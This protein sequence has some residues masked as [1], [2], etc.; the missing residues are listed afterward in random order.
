MEFSIPILLYH[1]IDEEDSVLSTRPAV[2]RKHLQFLSERGWRSLSL[3]EFTFYAW[4][5]KK[6]PSR[7]FFITFD[8]GYASLH[9]AAAKILEEFN[10]RATCFLCTSFIQHPSSPIDLDG[11][12]N[13]CF[14]S[15]EQ[16]RALQQT[17]LISFQSHTHTHAKFAAMSPLELSMDLDA[18]QSL[19]SC[20]LK[21]PK[22]H[23]QHLAWPWG[24][25]TEA[26]RQVAYQCGL[27]YQYTVER[28]SFVR[29]SSLHNMPRTCYDGATA[30]NFQAQFWLQVGPL[31]TMWRTTY[32]MLRQLRRPVPVVQP[33]QLSAVIVSEEDI[34]DTLSTSI[35]VTT[36]K[37]AHLS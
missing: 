28:Q 10:F 30:L 11:I 3:D 7:S 34:G 35:K 9:G 20:E 16:A 27:R 26:W 2:F 37:E 14:L 24:E 4:S 19:L 5:G 21:L 25:S 33:D 6:L 1:R 32:P 29:H 31:A 12:D 22:H 36:V 18:A 13:S 15:W 23:F 17:G 8:D